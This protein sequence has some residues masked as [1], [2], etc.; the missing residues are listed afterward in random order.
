[1]QM[2]KKLKENKKMIYFVLRSNF[3]ISIFVLDVGG[4][5]V[6]LTIFAEFRLIQRTSQ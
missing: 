4:R 6:V 1:M 2:I 5:E 3:C